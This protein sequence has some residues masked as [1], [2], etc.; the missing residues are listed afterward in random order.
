MRPIKNIEEFA[1]ILKEA[2]KLHDGLDGV[3]LPLL[4]KAIKNIE[5]KV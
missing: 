2:E 4:K 5:H 1:K 3:S